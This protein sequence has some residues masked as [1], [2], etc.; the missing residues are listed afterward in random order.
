MFDFLL[1]G[2][3]WHLVLEASRNLA[4]GRDMLLEGC[5]GGRGLVGVTRAGLVPVQRR[6]LQVSDI[7]Y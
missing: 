6:E 2:F 5:C 4:A 7:K 1:L 3:F